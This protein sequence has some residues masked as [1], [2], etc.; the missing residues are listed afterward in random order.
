M[1]L[2]NSSMKLV[3]PMLAFPSKPF[4]SED[5]VFEIKYD[6]TRCIA[7]VDRD[8]GRAMFLNRR[9]SFF[10]QR[11][12]EF[13]DFFKSV[14]AH[15]A[16]LDGELV[17]FDKGK[18]NFNLLQEREQ[19]SNQTRISVLSSL[20][21]AT[22][23]VFDILHKDGNDLLDLPLSER[24]SILESTLEESDYAILSKYVSKK[25][26]E[27]FK[28]VR[29]A[30]LEGV[31]AKAIKSPY[32]QERSKYWLKIKALS[33]IDAVVLGFTSTDKEQLSALLLGAYSS[34]KLV[35]IGKVGTGFDESERAA[36]LSRLSKLRSSKP[37]AEIGEHETAS[38]QITY[39][40]PELVAEVR[41][42]EL[43]KEHMLR[44]PAFL[45]L[46]S[47]KPA[48]DCTLESVAFA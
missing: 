38:E 25:G 36:L 1:S 18:P 13:A 33:T 48:R 41:F 4:D 34:G 28:R 16:I 42:M 6:G 31:M 24:K 11:Y 9:L 46:R 7:Y 26:K 17:V 2:W 32:V 45:R 47:D 10:Q 30:G 21:P 20:H 40:K 27:L 43:T 19:T 12:P 3:K 35:Y 14:K 23:V 37:Y 5:F 22:Y 39:A 44:A 15:R 29:K 8:S